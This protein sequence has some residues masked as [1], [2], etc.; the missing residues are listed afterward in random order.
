MSRG[1]L[2]VSPKLLCTGYFE[3]LARDSI[4]R[5]RFLDTYSK[6]GYYP[7]FTYPRLRWV[8]FVQKVPPCTRL[9]TLGV[10]F[11]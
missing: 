2:G 1:F 5:E 11:P 9:A 4:R 10:F 3:P 7:A 6:T 8:N